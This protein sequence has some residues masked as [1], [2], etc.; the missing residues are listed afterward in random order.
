MALVVDESKWLTVSMALAL[1]AVA[2]LAHRHRR[3]TLPARPRTLA[4]MN[5]FFGVTIGTMAV[6][7]L[8]A[9][10]VKLANGTLE[11]PPPLF[12][13]IGIAVGLPSWWVAFHTRALLRPGEDHGRATVGLNA[14]LAATLVLMGPHNLPLA[15]PGLLNVAYHLHA[16]RLVGLAILGASILVNAGLFVGSMVFFA[17]GRSFEE[18]R[19]GSPDR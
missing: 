11:G 18:F 19:A 5:L 17:S 10:T 6:G 12:Y 9:V 13:F 7:H 8:L 1:A 4:A 14:W 16:R 3:S 2:V 15:A